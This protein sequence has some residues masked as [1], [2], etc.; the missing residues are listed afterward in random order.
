MDLEPSFLIDHTE[1][2]NF[3]YYYSLLLLSRVHNIKIIH[4]CYYGTAYLGPDHNYGVVEVIDGS[5]F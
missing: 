5:R 1:V 2:R 3:L 4:S